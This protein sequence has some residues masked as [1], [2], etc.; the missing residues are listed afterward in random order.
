MDLLQNPILILTAVITLGLALGKVHYR[1]ISLDNAAVVFVGLGFG[2]VGLVVPPI[3]QTLG[4]A[5]FVFSIGM[6]SGPAFLTSFTRGGWA[7]VLPTAG[8]ILVSVG[9]TLGVTALGGLDPRLAL[10]LFTGG[11]SSNSALAVA[12][13]SSASALPALGHSLAYP[14][15]IL[16]ILVFVRLLPVVF[17]ADVAREEQAYQEDQAKRHPPLV[18]RTYRVD[19]PN[20]VGRPLGELSL[21]RLTGVNLS[22]VL[23]RGEIVVPTPSLV[24]D[25]GD[26][27]KGVGTEADLAHLTLVLGPE[28]QSDHFVE[29]PQDQH[30][31]AQWFVVTHRAVVHQP[32]SRLGLLETLGATVTRLQRHGVEMSPQGSTTLRYGDR[33]MVVASKGAMAAVK[34]RIGDTGRTVDQDLMPLFLTLTLGCIAGWTQVP[35]A[36]GVTFTLGLTGGVLLVSLL[37]SGLGKTGPILWAVSEPTNRFVRQLGLLLFLAAV[38]TQGGQVFLDVIADRGWT[39]VGAALGI[40]LLPLVLLAVFGRFVLRLNIVTLMGLISGAT[41]CSPAL[42]AAATV[43]RTNLPQVA[44]TTVFPF[45]MI[46]MMVCTQGLALLLPR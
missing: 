8:M 17:R 5:L 42:A 36:P 13:E 43:T 14:L 12:V 35:V 22:R 40:A 27:V 31:D 45:A 16:A 26:L 23:H 37:L 9:V 34:Q 11:R 15:A 28:T 38:G 18:T 1:G 46:F 2:H 6:Q 4:L 32:L 29:L 7:L 20:A 30:N 21:G 19:N 10:G 41:T 24:F 39:L 44:Y 33:I 3:F 25:A